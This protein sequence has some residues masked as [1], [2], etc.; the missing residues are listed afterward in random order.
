MLRKAAAG[1]GNPVIPARR[2]RYLAEIADA[3][4]NYNKTVEQQ[5]ELA[6]Q[7]Y[8]LIGATKIINKQSIENGDTNAIKAI[9]ATAA[10]INEKLLPLSKKMIDEWEQLKSVLQKRLF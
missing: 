6:S 10:G 2:S 7:L 8:Q 1:L 5:S 9:E 4:V 3:I